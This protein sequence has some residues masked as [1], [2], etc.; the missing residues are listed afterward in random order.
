M[1]ACSHLAARLRCFGEYIDEEGVYA[2]IRLGVCR[3]ARLASRHTR[4]GR[5]TREAVIDCAVVSRMAFIGSV[6]LNA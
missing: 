6:K 3:T 1:R 5:M 2:P 4:D